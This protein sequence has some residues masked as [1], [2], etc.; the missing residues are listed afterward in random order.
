M[1]SMPDELLGDLAPIAWKWLVRL[2]WLSCI[3]FFQALE[4]VRYWNGET[5][6]PFFGLYTAV[7]CALVIWYAAHAFRS[8]SWRN[9]ARRQTR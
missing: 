4:I 5:Y 6:R 3:I 1:V 2:I 8:A 9:K 7:I